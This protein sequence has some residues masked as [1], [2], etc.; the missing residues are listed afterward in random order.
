MSH[1]PARDLATLRKLRA[2]FLERTAGER[3]YWKSADDLALYDATFGERIGWKWDAVLAELSARGWQPRSRRVLDWGCGSGVA[4]RRVLAQWPHLESLALHDRSP[5]ARR[6]AAQ[7]AREAHPN[8]D[9]R[10]SRES[11]PDTLLV[12]SHVLSELPASELASLLALARQAREILWVEAGT[13]EDSRRLISEVREVLLPEFAVVAPCTHRARCGLLA[14]ANAPHWCHHFA[15]VPSAIFRDGKWVEFGRDLKIDLR[16][17]PYSFLV[18][19]RAAEHMPMPPGFS[20]VIGRPREATGYCKVLSCHADGV[21]EFMLQKRDAP[22]LHR[23]FHKGTA[24]SVYRWTI[25]N[26]RI[27]DG[28]AAD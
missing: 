15:P 26:G 2:R 5:L 14:A 28:E 16:S 20:R 23:A 13:H 1:W 8:V 21:R 18:L 4:G 22:E 19:E 3:D 11:G 10:E 6:F 7:R 27:V 9:V 25:E 17:L 24:R 12:L